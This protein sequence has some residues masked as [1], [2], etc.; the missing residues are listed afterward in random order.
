MLV[1][2]WL[3][4][5]AAAPCKGRRGVKSHESKLLWRQPDSSIMQAILRRITDDKLEPT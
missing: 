4:W 1:M 2:A 5:T 3:G